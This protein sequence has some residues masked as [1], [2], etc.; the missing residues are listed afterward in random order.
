[1][2]EK[3]LE[4]KLMTAC[5]KYGIKTVKGDARQNAGFPDRI[6]FNPNSGVIHYI[7]LKAD[8][9]YKQTE[10]QKYWQDIIESS[11]G[12]YI[13][14][15]GVDEVNAYIETY[16]KNN[17]KTTDTLVHIKLR[18]IKN[19]TTIDGINSKQQIGKLCDEILKD[20]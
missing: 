1:M 10:S 16:V 4:K 11:G 20:I 3:N 19:L 9:Y 18:R 12:R 13:L 15:N 2:L 7:E 6:V 14:L 8:T 5:R 17:K